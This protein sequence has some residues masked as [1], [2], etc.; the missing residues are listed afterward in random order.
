VP[1]DEQRS[2][3][4]DIRRSPAETKIIQCSSAGI[5][6]RKNQSLYSVVSIQ[7]TMSYSAFSSNSSSTE[8]GA[9][10][11]AGSLQT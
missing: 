4:E 9:E 11:Y 2:D 3:S 1:G 8:H 5:Y 7:L 10:Q 6:G